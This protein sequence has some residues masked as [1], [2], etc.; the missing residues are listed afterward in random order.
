MSTLCPLET[1]TNR[2]ASALSP[3]V[4]GTPAETATDLILIKRSRLAKMLDMGCTLLRELHTPGHLNWDPLF[5][6]PIRLT[7]NG[8]AH[9]LMSEVHAWIQSRVRDRDGPAQPLPKNTS[10]A[11]LTLVSARP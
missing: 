6:K 2:P 9:Y 8:S 3:E 7:T 11:P 5:P 1:E 10:T 4:H